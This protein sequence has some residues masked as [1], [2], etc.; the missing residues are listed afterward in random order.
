MNRRLPPGQI[1]EAMQRVIFDRKPIAAS[2]RAVGVPEEQL[3]AA[4]NDFYGSKRRLRAVQLLRDGGDPAKIARSYRTSVPQLKKWLDAFYDDNP[5]LYYLDQA[6]HLALETSS[7]LEGETPVPTPEPDPKPPWEVVMDAWSGEDDGSC[8]EVS[9][10]PMPA[11]SGTGGITWRRDAPQKIRIVQ[12][13]CAFH[14]VSYEWCGVAGLYLVRRTRLLVP[15]EGDPVAVLDYT[16][17]VRHADSHQIWLGLLA[18]M[19]R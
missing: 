11:K 2:A 10:H 18:G 12:H 17:A 7:V 16:D 9:V 14:P 5:E 4:L 6:P 3:R 1:G 8:P 19:L 15:E 13:T